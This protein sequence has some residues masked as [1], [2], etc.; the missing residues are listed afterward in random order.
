VSAER[1]IIETVYERWNRN[2]GDLALDL[3]D[4]QVEIQQ[5]GSLIGTA[6]IFR[7]HEGL[8]QSATELMEPFDRW[9]WDPREWGE[10][11]DYLLVTL[12]VRAIGGI[13]GVPT[14]NQVVHAWKI[15]DGLVTEF[16]VYENL[17]RA[18][19]TVRG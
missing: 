2:D 3:F 14:K 13:S 6:G 7:G 8:V 18:L 19:E 5:V 10:E 11:G 15:R 1:E 17:G 12:E 16:R 9:E 4:E